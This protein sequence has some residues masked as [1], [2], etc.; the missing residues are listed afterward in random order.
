MTKY[1]TL[2]DHERVRIEIDKNYL[3]F[4]CCDCAKVHTFGFHSI[5]DNIIDIE[6]WSDNRATGQLRRHRNIKLKFKDK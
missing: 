3:N 2:K 1:P 4:S 6:I 5:K